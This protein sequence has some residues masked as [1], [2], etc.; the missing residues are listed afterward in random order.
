MKV[1]RRLKIIIFFYKIA[2]MKFF[3]D[4]KLALFLSDI[5]IDSKKILTTKVYKEKMGEVGWSY[6][7]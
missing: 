3:R 4:K 1:L 7:L 5:A 6:A 2:I